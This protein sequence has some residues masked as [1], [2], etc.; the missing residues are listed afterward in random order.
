METL[1]DMIGREATATAERNHELWQIVRVLTGR[2]PGLRCRACG[3]D[4][5]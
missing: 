5:V 1:V 4:G 2:C 3:Q